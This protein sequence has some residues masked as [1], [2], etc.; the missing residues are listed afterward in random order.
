MAIDLLNRLTQTQTN[1]TVSQATE[2]VKNADSAEVARILRS[3]YALKGGDV[4]QGE[5]VSA[6]GTD[7]SL[8]LGDSVM[9]NARMDKELMLTPGQMMS[10]MVSSNQNG[11]L[12]LRPLF[13]N[14][15]ME[16]NAMKALDAAGIPVTDKTMALAEEMMRQGLPVNKQSLSNVYR[17]MGMYPDAGIAD[18]VMLHKMNI[19]VSEENLS[20]MRLYQT[21]QHYLFTDLQGLSSQMSD[22]MSEMAQTQSTDGIQHFI[23]GFL[24]IFQNPADQTTGQNANGAVQ[25]TD[26]VQTALLT[27]AASKLP[28]QGENAADNPVQ[29]SADGKVIINQEGMLQKNP[30]ET[31]HSESVDVATKEAEL[32][33]LL[34]R[35]ALSR[36]TG[37]ELL[38]QNLF[39]LLKEQFLMK[40]EDIQSADYIK[41]FYERLNEQVDKLQKLIKNAG[42]AD[43]ALGKEVGT[44]KSN[45]Q[46]M[47]QINEMYHY[48]QLPLKMNQAEAKGDL[49]VY[50][51]KQAK[52]GDDGKLT[53]LLHLSMLNLGNMDVFLSLEGQKLSTRFCLEKEELIDFIEA[54]IDSLNERLM[55]RGYQVQTTVSAGVKE[56]KTVI[57]E[58]MTTEISIPILTSQSFD[59]RC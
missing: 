9:L 29:L 23:R 43:S 34:N 33:K 15:G 19:P 31:L 10:F 46:F 11:K 51:R 48:V 56:E 26:G 39:S 40:P 55:K 6:N 45:I 58:I 57:D 38:T 53:A 25:V 5:L 8:L 22:F 54:N 18:L 14:T 1:T 52:T 16:Q 2:A 20:M 42:K 44:I 59:A 21:N 4:L 12:S 7:I 41:A 30:V 36:E 47:N 32:M 3:V 17:Q 35:D 27:D 13:A 50:K 49:Y 28:S 37:K 24:D